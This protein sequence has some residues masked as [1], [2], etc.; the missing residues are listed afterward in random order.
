[1]LQRCLGSN[2]QTSSPLFLKSLL[3][4]RKDT[5]E[6]PWE[7]A[8]IVLLH[9]TGFFLGHFT[10]RSFQLHM[11]E[12]STVFILREKFNLVS[13]KNTAVKVWYQIEPG[14][15]LNQSD[16]N[17]G[18]LM[19][20]FLEIMIQIV[21]NMA[22]LQLRTLTPYIGLKDTFLLVYRYLLHLNC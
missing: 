16:S 20:V 5:V 15:N 12:G 10:F 1:M 8:M 11:A 2:T 21:L 13:R 4:N 22:N 19:N 17:V 7:G 18:F 6:L 9:A 14:W 3:Q